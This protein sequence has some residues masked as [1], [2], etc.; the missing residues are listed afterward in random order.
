MK[1]KLSI[2]VQK[3]EKNQGWR[4]GEPEGMAELEVTMTQAQFAKLAGL[5]DYIPDRPHN[6]RMETFNLVFRNY[7]ILS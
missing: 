6:P 4:E 2:E 7:D 1:I 3:L 5:M